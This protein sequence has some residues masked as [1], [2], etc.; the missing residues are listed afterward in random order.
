MNFS[1]KDFGNTLSSSFKQMR[2]LG[3]RMDEV[4][5]TAPKELMAEEIQ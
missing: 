1:L 2:Q 5:E 4:G 3:N